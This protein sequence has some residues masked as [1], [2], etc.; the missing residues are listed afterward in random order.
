MTSDG[1]LLAQSR[2]VSGNDYYLQA[3]KMKRSDTEPTYGEI[4]VKL[5]AR[6]R[7][8]ASLK[9]TFGHFKEDIVEASGQGTRRKKGNNKL[10]EDH[11][12][13]AKADDFTNKFKQQLKLHRLDSII[14]LKDM[15]GRGR[16]RSGD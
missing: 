14:R 6:M 12:V 2:K 5:Q 8:L 13:N 7:K 16:P 9:S 15:I 3:Q 4:S 10:L 11:E 1:N